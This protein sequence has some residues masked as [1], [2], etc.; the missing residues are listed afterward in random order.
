M[1][2]EIHKFQIKTLAL[3]GKDVGLISGVIHARTKLG[4]DGDGLM[5]WNG[6]GLAREV[7]TSEVRLLMQVR[8]TTKDQRIL[9]GE[10][11]VGSDGDQFDIQGDGEMSV[12]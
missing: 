9:S 11:W 3:D 4:S 12:S 2:D 1:S 10:A 7:P 6:S 8:A 5:D